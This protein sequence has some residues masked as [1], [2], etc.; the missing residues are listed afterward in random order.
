MMTK[1][2]SHRVSVVLILILI[3]ILVYSFFVEY[4]LQKWHLII[5]DVPFQISQPNE[6]TNSLVELSPI[7]IKSSREI[8]LLPGFDHAD[9]VIRL[10]QDPKQQLIVAI[11]PNGKV[12]R[13]DQFTQKV[14]S[15]YNFGAVN[16]DSTYISS[17][18]SKAISAG[19]ITDNG[20]NWCQCMGCRNGK[21]GY[22]VMANIAR[23]QIKLLT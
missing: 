13:W 1:F 5:Q 3:P 14:V 21:R 6:F 10:A 22:S 8:A 17:D 16:R 15:E 9:G 4:N 20:I 23:F 7:T 2:F 19:K 11:Y 18:G 12:I